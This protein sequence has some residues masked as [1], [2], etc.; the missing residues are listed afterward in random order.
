[1]PSPESKSTQD[2]PPSPASPDDKYTR[3]E[4][5]LRQ[6]LAL[7]GEISE[8]KTPLKPARPY[9]YAHAHLPGECIILRKTSATASEPAGGFDVRRHSNTSYPYR[10]RRRMIRGRMTAAAAAA[11]AAAAPSP[12]TTA[13]ARKQSASDDD[14]E[15]EEED[16]ASVDSSSVQ[17][18]FSPGSLALSLDAI[19]EGNRG[20]SELVFRDNA[21]MTAM[22]TSRF[23]E[24]PPPTRAMV[25]PRSP[26]SP[27]SPGSPLQQQ[28]QQEGVQQSPPPPPPPSGRRPT[29]TSVSIPVLET[30]TRPSASHRAS[31]VGA[32]A[33]PLS[34]PRWHVRI[35]PVSL[36]PRERNSLPP[37]TPASPAFVKLEAVFPYRF[38]ANGRTATTTGWS[39][40][41]SYIIIGR[42]PLVA[43][44]N[45][46]M[47]DSPPLQCEDF[48]HAFQ[49]VHERSLQDFIDEWEYAA[50]TPA[51]ERDDGREGQTSDRSA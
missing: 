11:A 46:G 2:E 51:G 32:E 31:S 35:L 29:P 30:T 18:P 45:T 16:S 3:L 12:T 36:T 23:P 8:T 40:E 27:T 41:G 34:P 14:N 19:V 9:A 6:T 49:T 21:S 25:S 42:P 50:G 26:R 37:N 13:T 15:E 7:A 10:T 39:S 33:R 17:E 24:S 28:Q 5:L 43:G 47:A 22:G 20:T 4:D 1:M 44:T 48:E 38:F